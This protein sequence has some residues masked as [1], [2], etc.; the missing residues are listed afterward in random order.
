M[1]L[2]TLSLIGGKHV[3]ISPVQQSCLG[4]IVAKYPA[5]HPS[6]KN[7]RREFKAQDCTP[8]RI[9]TQRNFNLRVC[10]CSSIHHSCIITIFSGGKP[11]KLLQTRGTDG[12]YTDCPRIMQARY[13]FAVFLSINHADL[14]APSHSFSMNVRDSRYGM[15]R[16]TRST[17]ISR[18]FIK[19][20]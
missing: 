1:L 14:H 13:G 5:E 8:H 18:S 2:G 4:Y 16:Q 15:R 10:P 7:F 6:E 17:T 9:T 3:L 11:Q 20:A 19:C 12:G